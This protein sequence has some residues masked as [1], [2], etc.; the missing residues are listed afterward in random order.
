MADLRILSTNKIFWK[1]DDGVAAVLLEMFPAAIERVNP[2]P[3]PKPQELVPRWAIEID[4]SSYYF[5]SFRLLSRNDRYFGP[6]SQLV[7]Y[8]GKTGA[9]VPEHIAQEYGN[10]WKPREDEHPTVA[11]AY[12][13]EYRA[14]HEK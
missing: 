12:W 8:F 9:V 2:R 5:V 14:I 13:A 4:P 1:I 3:Q 10:L 11:Q 7:S 6:P